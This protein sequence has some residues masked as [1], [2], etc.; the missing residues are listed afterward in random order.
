MG[1]RSILIVVIILMVLTTIPHVDALETFTIDVTTN[2]KQVTVTGRMR[3]V[4]DDISLTVVNKSNNRTVYTAKTT[5]DEEGNYS[6]HFS[7]EEYGNYMAK[8]SRGT[9]IYGYESFRVFKKLENLSQRDSRGNQGYI[10]TA[11]VSNVAKSYI[12]YNDNNETIVT[13]TIDQDKMIEAIRLAEEADVLLD[14]NVEENPKQLIIYLNSTIFETARENNKKIVL[15]ANDVFFKVQPSEMKMKDTRELKFVINQIPGKSTTEGVKTNL[16]G[17]LVSSIYEVQLYHRISN[18]EKEMYYFRH[19]V[20]LS[21][22][23]SSRSVK[24]QE[25][26][27]LYNY[28]ESIQYWEYFKSELDN[29]KENVVFK[30]DYFSKYAVIEYDRTYYDIV[31]HWA[32]NEIEVL[33]SRNIVSSTDEMNFYPDAKITRGEFAA[34]IARAVELEEAQYR[35][36]FKD[37]DENAWYARL[38]EAAAWAGIVK[39]SEGEFR[40]DAKVTR[41]EMAVMMIRAMEYKGK[42]ALRFNE[43]ARFKDCNEISPW[44]LVYVDKAIHAG[45]VQGVTYTTF[46][47]KGEATRAQAAVMIYRLVNHQN[48][49][50]GY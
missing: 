9:K 24:N 18:T 37:V 1:K 3:V 44:A 43:V 5:T 19:P 26:V 32:R 21:I 34:F 14:V 23:Y 42:I 31:N 22:P 29:E 13:V 33:A 36:M 6:F 45:I 7:V 28:N 11:E 4:N 16:L 50:Y 46:V 30:P 40:P 38:V 41:E 48:L 15:K 25:K 35:G 8:V 47:P 2:D 49:S 20:Y 12:Q 10:S 39:G 17:S 27:N